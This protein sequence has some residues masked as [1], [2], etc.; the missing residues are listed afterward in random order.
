MEFLLQIGGTLIVVVAIVIALL[1][2]LGSGL[3]L[4]HI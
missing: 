1:L 2:I 4:I 3:S